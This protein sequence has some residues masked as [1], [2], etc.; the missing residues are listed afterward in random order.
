MTNDRNRCAD[1]Q[2]N[3]VLTN[4]NVCD[5]VNTSSHY[6]RNGVLLCDNDNV[7][8]VLLLLVTIIIKWPVLFLIWW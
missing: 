8:Q 7:W 2:A 1:R 4:D 6:W 3:D 5:G